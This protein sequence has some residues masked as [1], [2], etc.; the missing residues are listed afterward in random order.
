M[1]DLEVVKTKLGSGV[2]RNK[3]ATVLAFFYKSIQTRGAAFL[4]CHN[5]I[6]RQA[7]RLV[8]LQTSPLE[9]DATTVLRLII[10]L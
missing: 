3:K 7:V 10:G 9:T 6:L 4:I 1:W 5:Q 8:L 2:A